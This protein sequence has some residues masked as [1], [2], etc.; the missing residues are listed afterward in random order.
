MYNLPWLNENSNRYFP[1]KDSLSLLDRTRRF[2]LPHNFIVDAL[3]SL[4]F[5]F[6]FDVYVSKIIYSPETLTIYLSTVTGKTALVGSIQNPDPQ[7]KNEVLHLE[8]QEKYIG[9]AGKLII[10]SLENMV[11]GVFE[12]FLD[13]VC[14]EPT[15]VIKMSNGVAAINGITSGNVVL[16]ARENTIIT[17]ENNNIAIGTFD[18]RCACASCD[19]IKTI[20]GLKPI[21]NNI[22]IRGIG[23]ATITPSE[24]GISYGNSC[25]DACCDCEEIVAIYDRLISLETRLLAAENAS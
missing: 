13:D 7:L 17:V 25:E 21:N 15:R 14:L 4:T 18:G 8:G 16:E 1:F 6:K 22:D 20:N 23:C 24:N 5:D 10:G 2:K 12:Y 19:C 9:S 11:E 3:V